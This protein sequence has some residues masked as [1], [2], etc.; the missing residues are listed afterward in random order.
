M[1]TDLVSFKIIINNL[2]KIAPENGIAQHGVQ[3]L[4]NI[5]FYD[6]LRRLMVANFIPIYVVL[7]GNFF[8]I[9]FTKVPEPSGEELCVIQTCCSNIFYIYSTP[10]IVTYLPNKTNKMHNCRILFQSLHLRVSV[11]MTNLRV[12]TEYI[13][14]VMYKVQYICTRWFKYDREKL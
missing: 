12:L 3:N 10:C 14:V 2:K 4:A 7:S 1:K 9:L 8:T 6:I 11:Y 13:G 5:L